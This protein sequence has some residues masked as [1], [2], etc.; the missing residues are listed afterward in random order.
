MGRGYIHTITKCSN[1][2]G[3]DYATATI[4]PAGKQVATFARSGR[5]EWS[6]RE[7]EL[8]K[9]RK[10]LGRAAEKEE[11]ETQIDGG[12][13]REMTVAVEIIRKNEE[14]VAGL[15]TRD[16]GDGDQKMRDQDSK[17]KLTELEVS[18]HA[19]TAVTDKTP[20]LM[21]LL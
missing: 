17:P 19:T 18:Q 13:K 6:E 8:Q 21:R 14:E 3:S 2:A 4:C 1:C 10:E 9:A 11:I 5:D 12:R 16:G 20:P 15:P 7:L